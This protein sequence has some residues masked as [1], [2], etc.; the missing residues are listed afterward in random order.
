[1]AHKNVVHTRPTLSASEPE[2]LDFAMQST[3][4]HAYQFG[5]FRNVAAETLYLCQQVLPFEHFAGVG[6]A[7]GSSGAPLIRYP[8]PWAK[9]RRYRAAAAR[10]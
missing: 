5:S 6:A 1:M 9:P 10:R 7:V 8:R 2:A 4:L 3:A